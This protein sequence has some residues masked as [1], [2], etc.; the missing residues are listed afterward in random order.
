MK[1][2][3]WKKE[4][5]TQAMITQPLC[6]SWMGLF[7]HSQFQL[8]GPSGEWPGRDTEGTEK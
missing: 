7:G 8:E 4:L 2:Q 3:P 6:P 1:P 5:G